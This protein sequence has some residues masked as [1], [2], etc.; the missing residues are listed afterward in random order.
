MNIIKEKKINSKIVGFVLYLTFCFAGWYSSRSSLTGYLGMNGQFSFMCNDIV[1]FFIAGL[2]PILIYFLVMKVLTRALRQVAYLPVAQMEYSFPYFYI[3]ANI[4]IGL[5]NVLY[6][7]LPIASIWGGIIVPV[8]STACFFIWYLAFI[9]KNYVKNYNW[10]T[11]VMYFGRLYI[12]IALLYTVFG[13]IAE[14]LL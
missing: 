12:I 8:I 1:A 5:F 10:K 3:G 7:F 2:V 13:I 9:C 6:F 11:I 14:V 4:V